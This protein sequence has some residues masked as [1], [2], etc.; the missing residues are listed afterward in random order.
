[1]AYKD[2]AD[3]NEWRKRDY[4]NNQD[5]REYQ[6]Q[7][8][9]EYRKKN[10]EALKEY[11]EKNKEKL[12]AY[13]KEWNVKNKDKIKGY[14]DAN[15]EYRDQHTK[16]WRAAHP[17]YQKEYYVKNRDVIYE[18]A[19]HYNCLKRG[20]TLEEFEKAVVAQGNCCAL[21]LKPESKK[22]K[23]KVTRLAVDHDHETG[24]FRALLCSGCNTGIGLLKDDPTLLRRAAE[25]IEKHKII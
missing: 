9:R 12:E 7:Y 10:A 3:R 5:S 18:K 4:K 17:E 14:N 13:N 15:R 6:L 24:K 8:Q 19:R 22:F 21:C 11:R 25:Y 2:K 23:G 16:E 1:M 20:T